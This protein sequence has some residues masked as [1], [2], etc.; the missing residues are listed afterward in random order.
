[1]ITAQATLRCLKNEHTILLFLGQTPSKKANRN[2]PGFWASESE[3]SK[4]MLTMLEKF[5]QW[6]VALTSNQENGAADMIDQGF[7][8][9]LNLYAWGNP[10]RRVL[11][12][13]QIFFAYTCK[14]CD[15]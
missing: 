7:L 15:R 4:I 5:L 13:P 6:E 2:S 3:T 12:P 14:Q 1:V 11:S 10:A 8:P 9:F